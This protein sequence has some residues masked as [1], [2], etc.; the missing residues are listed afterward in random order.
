MSSASRKTGN[1]DKGNVRRL[2]CNDLLGVAVIYTKEKTMKNQ[3]L[4]AKVDNGKYAVSLWRYEETPSGSIRPLLWLSSEPVFETDA[5][6]RKHLI[7]R[8]NPEI[9]ENTETGA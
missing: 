5:D 1:A 4:T 7:E 8:L 9:L 3:I 2:R 6:A